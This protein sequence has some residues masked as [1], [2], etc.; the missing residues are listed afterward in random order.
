[1]PWS[2][3][4][5]G[6]AVRVP[7]ARVAL[8]TSSCYPDSCATAF[9]F[10]AELGYD[11]VEVM[12]WTDPVSQD[13]AA[14]QRLAD[15]YSTPVVA[16]HAPCLLLT[17]RVWG[18]DPWAKLE[19]SRDAAEALGARTV[20]VHPPFLWQ[21]E[22]ARGFVEGLQRMQDETDVVF[23]VENMYPWRAG[24]REIPAYQPHWNPL[25]LDYHAYALDVSHTSVSQSDPLAMLDA[26][27]SRLA[28]VHLADGTGSNRDEHLIPGRG[29]QPCAALL[30]RLAGRGFA[31]TVVLEVNTRR[32]ASREER[33][34]DLA[35]ALAF[36]RLN[37]VAAVD[38]R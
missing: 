23:A 8:S 26:M 13:V 9:E 31:G 22:Y 32:A 25:E 30:E 36:T 35:E 3:D 18:T 15:Q 27:G 5:A 12:V 14:L 7:T 2:V 17:Q 1:M 29:E 6:Q 38:A 21:R 24:S 10:A 19:R 16:V 34:A 20:V 11:G 37:L 4:P 33:A 28:H